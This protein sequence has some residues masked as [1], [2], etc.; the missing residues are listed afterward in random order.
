MNKKTMLRLSS[1]AGILLVGAIAVMINVVSHFAYFRLDMSRGKVYSISRASKRIL[2]GLSDP[3]LVRVYYSKNLPPQIIVSRNYLMDLLKE[4]VPAS[5]GNLKL[6]YVEVEQFRPSREEAVRNGI[7]PVRFDIFTKEKFEQRE[8]F[9]GLTIQLRDKKDVIPYLQDTTG[10]EYE[11]TSRIKTLATETKPVIGFVS[12]YDAMTSH[13]LELPAA[14]RLEA[15]YDVKNIDFETISV[16]SGVPAGVEALFFLGPQERVKEKDLFFLDQYLLSGRSLCL[17][18]DTKKMD[19]NSFFA[20]DNDTGL[21]DFLSKHGLSLQS[22]I[23]MDMQCQPIQ[24]SARQ[25]SF[26]VSN[27]VSYPPFIVSRNLNSG[28][29]VTKGLDSLVLPFASPI[30]IST[31]SPSAKVTILAMS[32]KNSWVK[33]SG[34]G[35][36]S[37]NPFQPMDASDADLKG[38]FILAAVVQDKFTP[39]FEV[40]PEGIKP[41]TYIREAKKKGRLAVITTSKFIKREFHM[42][43]SNYLFFLN[44]A[45]W[46]TQDADL[47]AIRSK[48][49]RFHP[50]REI[51]APL[52]KTVRYAN[53]FVP[54]LA[55]V[56]IGLFNWRKRRKRQREAVFQYSS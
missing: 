49:V 28:H 56:L 15:R 39:Y 35:Y 38:P 36:I 50:L 24:I 19:M 48:S 34:A 32:S 2:Q 3:V 16:D 20:T 37:L 21:S 46:M 12:G 30:E 11:L 17:A 7:V 18:V 40:P 22:G 26:V 55:A 6:S 43:E 9:L 31:G 5:K 13:S 45:D 14:R 51:P 4:Y 10:L 47:I 29:P 52:K 54:P 23:V 44:M 1:S 42:P 33:S 8:G 27:I 53:I 41:K 25:G